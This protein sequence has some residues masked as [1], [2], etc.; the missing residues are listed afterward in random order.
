MNDYGLHKELPDDDKRQ[1]LFKEQR[2]TRGF[3]DTETWS[4]SSSMARFIIP[5]LERFKELHCCHPGTLTMEKWD[6]ILQEMIDGFKEVE[7]M[8]E[9]DFDHAKV[10]RGL[11]LFKKWYLDLWW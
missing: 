3:D 11:K 5:R 2:E 9:N 4:L 7:R 1:V 8:D 6:K 10:K